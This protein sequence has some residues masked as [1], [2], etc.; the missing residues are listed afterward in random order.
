MRRD[1]PPPK[2]H[3]CDPSLREELHYEDM[4]ALSG[5]FRQ[6]ALYESKFSPEQR[7]RL[8]ACSADLERPAQWA[9][10][11]S[12]SIPS[13]TAEDAAVSLFPSFFGHPSGLDRSHVVMTVSG[14]FIGRSA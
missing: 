12:D 13:E 8:M 2:L 4:I 7:T 10:R 6:W 11:R 9:P 5:L 3:E 1:S 14:S